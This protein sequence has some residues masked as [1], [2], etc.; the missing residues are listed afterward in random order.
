MPIRPIRSLIF[1]FDG[2]ILDTEVPAFEAWQEIYEQHGAALV[3]DT[4]GRAL[5]GS[6]L[7]VDHIAELERAAGRT[8]D[9]ES[10]HRRRLERKLALIEGQDVLPGVREY[11]ADGKRRG[12]KLAIV[13]SSPHRWV[14]GYLAKLG[15]IDAFEV[16]VCGE[17]APRPKPHPD[18]Y[19]QALEQL[20]LLP[21]EGIAFEDSP[22]GITA[23]RAAGIFCV[24]VPNAISSQFPIDHA[25]VRLAS[26]ADMPLEALLAHVE[27]DRSSGS[28]GQSCGSGV[29]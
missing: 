9:G 7:E 12:L 10:I 19:Q 24:A 14:E 2:L 8:L 29:E 18:L 27:H 20:H 23:A 13:S 6:G 11:I 4:W 5:G 26:L 15:L 17:D 22:N 21:E 16:V 25:D 28:T 1:D 3:L